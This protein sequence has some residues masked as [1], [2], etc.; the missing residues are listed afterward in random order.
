MVYRH[1]Y[2]PADAQNIQSASKTILVV[3]DDADLGEL[4]LQLLDLHSEQE[5]T[6]YHAI[7]A[8]D[9]MQALEAVKSI[10]PDLFLLDYYLPRMNGLELYDRLHSLPGLEQVPTIFISANPPRQEIEKRNLVSLKKPF[11]LRLLLHTIDR[12]LM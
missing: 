10:K 11:N 6:A 3:E 2:A 12:L 9:S 5:K 8:V 1:T 7:V 4:I